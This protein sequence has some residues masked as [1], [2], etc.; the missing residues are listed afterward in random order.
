MSIPFTLDLEIEQLKG[1]LSFMA[2]KHKYNMN[3][4]KVVEISQQLDGLIV[5]SMKKRAAC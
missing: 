4:P 2:A 5:E 1:V 3:H